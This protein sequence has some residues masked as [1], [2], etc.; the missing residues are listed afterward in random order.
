VLGLNLMGDGLRDVLDPRLPAPRDEPAR[1]R[2]AL[3]P[4]PSP[5]SLLACRSCNPRRRPRSVGAGEVLGVIGESGSGKSMTALAIMGCCRAARPRPGRVLLD[6]DRPAARARARRCAHARPRHR[7]GVPGADDRAQPAQDDRRAGGR[8]GAVAR[9]RPARRGG[10]SPAP[11]STASGCRSE[12]PAD[13]YPHE[14]S[15]G[16]RQRVV[17]AMAVALR[18]KLLIA[19]EPTT[20]LDVT[21]Q[22]QILDLLRGW[23]T[24]TAWAW[25]SDHPRPRGGRRPRRP[26]AI[27]RDGEVVEAGPTAQ[28]FREMRH[29]YTRALLAASTHRPARLPADAGAAARGR[30]RGARL[31]AAAPAPVRAARRELPRGEGVSFTIGAARMSASS[32]SR[33][34][35]SRRSPAPSSGSSRCRAAASRSTARR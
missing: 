25:C 32:A 28:V 3:D 27:M 15:G 8:D 1:D 29:P 16:Q 4:R 30:G 33:A 12:V 9:R 18:P 6:G 17:I 14:L 21:T 26:L 20:A 24:R 35:A 10:A 11:R 31:P 2:K 7:H 13:R 22:A 23:S 34:A 19:D 5:M